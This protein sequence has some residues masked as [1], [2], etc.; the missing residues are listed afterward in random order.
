VLPQ[1]WNGTPLADLLEKLVEDY[2]T[3]RGKGGRGAAYREVLRSIM[4][5]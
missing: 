5:R 1:G 3:E 4:L 2:L